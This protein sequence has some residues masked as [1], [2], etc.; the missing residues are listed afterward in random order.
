VA[1]YLDPWSKL[2][3]SRGYAP[4]EARETALTVLPDIL[5]YDRNGPA[6]Y[7]NGRVVTDDVYDVR[8]AFLTHRQVTSDGVGPHDD[9]LTEFP[10]LG[11]PNAEASGEPA[12]LLASDESE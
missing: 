1:N 5:R 8:M 9:Y 4:A 3:E 12:T 11:P 7:P 2:L 6:H 10:F